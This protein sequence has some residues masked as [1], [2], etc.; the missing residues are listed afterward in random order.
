MSLMLSVPDE[1]AF[2][3]R[4][5]SQRTGTPAET[6][7]LSALRAHFPPIPEA[8]QVEFDALELASDEDYSRFEQSLG[9]A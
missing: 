4:E 9:D 8:L 3:V 7:L 1:I 6:L 2:T 5:V